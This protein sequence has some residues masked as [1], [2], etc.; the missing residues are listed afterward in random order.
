[1]SLLPP[2]SDFVMISRRGPKTPSSMARHAAMS[3]LTGAGAP[4]LRAGKRKLA[5]NRWR[6]VKTWGIKRRAG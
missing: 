5:T 3:G 6:A 4:R 1:M 2:R